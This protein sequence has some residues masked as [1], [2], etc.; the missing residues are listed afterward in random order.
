MN[1]FVDKNR[2]NSPIARPTIGPEKSPSSP[3]PS[4]SP[5]SSPAKSTTRTPSGH[6]AGL[7][8][9]QSSVSQTETGKTKKHKAA[10]EPATP[11][12]A[13][14]DM[15]AF[16]A[17]QM[18]QEKPAATA[19]SLK[20]GHAEV[21]AHADSDEPALS[22]EHTEADKPKRS[23]GEKVLDTASA[24]NP[25]LGRVRGKVNEARENGNNAFVA[26][27]KEA[28]K[29]FVDMGVGAVSAVTTVASSGVG[30]TAE[31][32]PVGLVAVAA[33]GAYLKASG[34]NEYAPGIVKTA[35]KIV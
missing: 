24:I 27:A 3:R 30:L 19:H 31:A 34:K 17:G 29:T 2:L 33:T 18:V 23:I 11:K 4:D 12:E 25:V 14:F 35:S 6:L 15:D 9:R 5:G 28:G 1:A 8:A 32:N 13:A 16:L 21:E 22:E 10:A 7:S 26:G 20:E